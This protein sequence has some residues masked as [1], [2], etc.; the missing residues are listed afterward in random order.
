M[1]W[2]NASPAAQTPS[3]FQSVPFAERLA[4]T[5]AQSVAGPLRRPASSRKRIPFETDARCPSSLTSRPS[6]CVRNGSR[7]GHTRPTCLC[8]GI[9]VRG[10]RLVHGKGGRVRIV[11]HRWN[12]TV[13]ALT[14]VPAYA[15]CRTE[16]PM[17]TSPSARVHHHAPGSVGRNAQADPAAA[18]LSAGVPHRT[19]RCLGATWRQ[20]ANP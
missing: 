6:P 14:R 15:P 11:E 8:R 19:G 18:L 16:S 12:E 20:P 9:V 1:S 10:E 4:V 7:Y 17:A 13:L 5:L 2:C 3:A